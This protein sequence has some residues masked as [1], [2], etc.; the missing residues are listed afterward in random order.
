MVIM[1][2]IFCNLN[3]KYE[4]EKNICLKEQTKENLIQCMKEKEKFS[5][6]FYIPK[7]F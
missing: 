1:V 4:E 5:N 7:I 6:R 3:I 2:F